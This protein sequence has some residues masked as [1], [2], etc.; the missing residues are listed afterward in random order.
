[1]RIA[2]LIERFAPGIGGVENVAWQVAHELTR[3]GEDVTVFARESD[4]DSQVTVEQLP[5]SAR[6]QPWRVH[7]YDRAAYRRTHPNHRAAFD[8]VHSF[9]RTRHQDLYRAGGG[10]HADYLQ[11]SHSPWGRRLRQLSPRHR[12]LLAHERSVFSDPAQ[13]IQCSSRLVADALVERE[14]VSPERLLILPNGVDVERFSARAARN[15]GRRQRETAF[16]SRDDGSA[17]DMGPLWLFP[18]SGWRRKGL[19]ELFRALRCR[20]ARNHRL[21][22]AGRDEPQAWR[23]RARALGI[24]ERVEFLGERADLAPLYHAVDAMVLPTRYDPFANVTLEAAAAGLPI[25]TS[26]ANGAAEWLAGDIRVVEDPADSESLARAM[27]DHAAA[28]Y[29]SELGARLAKR[30]HEFDWREHVETLRSEYALL[31]RRRIAREDS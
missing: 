12:V 1:M 5:V 9:S 8:V 29:R 26:R 13:R 2:I 20:P 11:R 28:D 30:A 6:W 15:E 19:E 23:R 24:A 25:V 21:W 17:R 14:G 18:G 4:P 10:S 31:R 22:I 16:G 27:A 3:R 7:A